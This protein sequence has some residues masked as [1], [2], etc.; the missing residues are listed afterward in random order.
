MFT[1]RYSLDSN[2]NYKYRFRRKPL[3]E[4]GRDEAEFIGD[5]KKILNKEGNGSG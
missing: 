1:Q 3:K 5:K 2:L 4:V